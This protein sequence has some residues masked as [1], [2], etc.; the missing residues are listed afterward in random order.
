M[1]EYN[2]IYLNGYI[3]IWLDMTTDIVNADTGTGN[4]IEFSACVCARN[5]HTMVD[6]VR[7]SCEI[8]T[9]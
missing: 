8:E 5:E 7:I 1:F 4:V 9:I 3:D 2:N 6:R